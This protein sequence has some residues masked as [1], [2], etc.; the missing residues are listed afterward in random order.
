MIG[1]RVGVVVV[2]LPLVHVALQHLVG[3]ALEGNFLR[4]NGQVLLFVGG[5]RLEEG[6]EGDTSDT[7]VLW[8]LGQLLDRDCHAS[9]AI[10]DED[11]SAETCCGS[12]TAIEERGVG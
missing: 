12:Q 7:P 10:L 11:T 8:L 3:A 1:A 9:E 2:E 4:R 6:E 5:L